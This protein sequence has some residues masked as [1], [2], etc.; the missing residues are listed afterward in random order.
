MGSLSLLQGIFPTQGSNWGLRYYRWILHLLSYQGSPEGRV[1]CVQFLSNKFSDLY[2]SD[3][4]PLM[5]SVIK[6]SNSLRLWRLP[7][8]PPRKSHSGPGG[9]VG[10]GSE[11][12]SESLPH[13][14][15]SQKRREPSTFWLPAR[16]LQEVTATGTFL[17]AQSQHTVLWP[18]SC[19]G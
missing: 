8:Q 5:A 11:V 10:N 18:I 12:R 17:Q 7:A 16:Q 13:R 9:E 2:L 1:N 3:L 14:K 6:H 19:L 4:H 15:R